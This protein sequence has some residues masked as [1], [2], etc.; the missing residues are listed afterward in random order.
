[1]ALVLL[2]LALGAFLVIHT[3]GAGPE[4]PAAADPERLRR[5]VEELTSAPLTPRDHEHVDGLDRAA[6][7]V[8]A[9]FRNYTGDVREQRFS[10]GGRTYRNVIA[11]FGPIGP[12]RIVVGAHYD[13]AGPLPGADDNASGVAGLL[14]L[15]RLLAQDALEL[16][17][18][19][20]AFSLEEPPYFGSAEMG[21]AVHAASIA[22]EGGRVRLMIALEMIGY[23]TDAPASQRFPAPGLGLL[24]PRT[25]NFIAV[26]G[27]LGQGAIVKRVARAMRLATPL[28][29]QSIAA[30]RALPG[31]DLSDHRSYWD[32]GWK[33]LMITDTADYRNAN[34]H[35]ANDT[36]ATLDWRR[37]AHVVTGVHAAVLEVS[38]P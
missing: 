17:V 27:K 4:R 7:Y 15:S 26:V 37:M 5:H 3:P 10:A 31:V 9:E 8:E 21:S 36:P 28:D 14:E 18:E 11:G 33:A 13:T 24:Y 22:A 35:T 19:L 25:G 32:H 38:S 34:Y 29:V 20:V 30:P 16:R 23:F 2:A 6:A 1:M 12:E